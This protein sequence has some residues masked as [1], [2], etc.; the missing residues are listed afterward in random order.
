MAKARQEAMWLSLVCKITVLKGFKRII[1]LRVHTSK[2][3]FFLYIYDISTMQFTVFR[4]PAR[5]TEPFPLKPFG[6]EVASHKFCILI[7]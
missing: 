2:L 1:T 7:G 5:V 3:F 4:K 6:A